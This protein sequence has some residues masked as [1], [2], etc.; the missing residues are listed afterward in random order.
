MAQGRFPQFSLG[1]KLR[2]HPIICLILRS[3][4]KHLK[5]NKKYVKIHFK[6]ET[7]RRGDICISVLTGFLG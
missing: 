3:F 7:G 1:G 4:L 2:H 6:W 5:K